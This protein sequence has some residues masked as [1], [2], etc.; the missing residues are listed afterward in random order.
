MKVVAYFASFAML[1]LVL[2]VSAFAKDSHSRKF[3]LPDTVRVGSAQLTPG[4]YEAEWNGPANN[5]KVDI[6]QNHKIVATTEGKIQTMQRPAPY[7]SVTTKTLKDNT[8]R[9]DE[10][11]FGNHTDALVLG[12]E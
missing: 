10:I 12:G 5:V 3:T 9:L 7:D 1:T 4:N 6:L 11:E 2:S 8:K